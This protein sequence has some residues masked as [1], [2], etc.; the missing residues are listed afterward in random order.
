MFNESL[1][2]HLVLCGL[3]LSNVKF[4]AIT[5]QI[6]KR[7]YEKQKGKEFPLSNN[8]SD[9][10]YQIDLAKHLTTNFTDST[11]RIVAV[12]DNVIPKEE[13]DTVR[14][15]FMKLNSAYAYDSYDTGYDEDNDNVNWIVKVNVSYEIFVFLQITIL[16]L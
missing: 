4:S 11:G 9:D 5:L 16:L 15:Y 12:F 7:E 10:I 1:S 3:I 6:V 13:L 8:T 2:C 14:G